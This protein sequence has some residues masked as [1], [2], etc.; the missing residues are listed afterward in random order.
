MTINRD[1]VTETTY[2]KLI[3]YILSKSEIYLLPL[4][5]TKRLDA[6]ASVDAYVTWSVRVMGILSL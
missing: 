3:D 1:H 5:V 6:T 4:S 2:Y